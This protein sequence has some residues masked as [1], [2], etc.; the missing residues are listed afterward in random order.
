MSYYSYAHFPCTECDRLGFDG[1]TKG[2]L[3][4]DYFW[5]VESA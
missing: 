5:N 3:Q 1:H 2:E 4:A